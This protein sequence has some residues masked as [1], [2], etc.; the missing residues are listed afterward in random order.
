M[1]KEFKPGWEYIYSEAL[2]QGV[3]VNIKTGRI[4]CEDGTLYSLGEA[5][6]MN[7]AKQ[8]ITPEVHHVKRI[9]GGSITAVIN[10]KNT[11]HI[12]KEL[13]KEERQND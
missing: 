12:H 8:E 9:F 2:K 1:P 3:A 6:I 4:Y 5:K 13:L 11:L 10:K 7:A